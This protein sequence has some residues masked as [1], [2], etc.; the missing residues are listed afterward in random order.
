MGKI[1][2]TDGK[3]IESKLVERE[4]PEDLLKSINEVG[5]KRSMIFNEFLQISLQRAG[6]VKREQE[7]LEKI[8]NNGQSLQNRIENAYKK[9]KLKD[10]KEYNWRFDGRSKFIGRPIPEKKEKK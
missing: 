6:L 3:P 10:E 8:K 4:I 5:N 9:M 1:V 2:G 7:L